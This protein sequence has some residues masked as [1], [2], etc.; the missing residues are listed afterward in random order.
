[1]LVLMGVLMARV[2]VEAVVVTAR[3]GRDREVDRH[4]ADEPQYQH[5]H[6]HHHHRHHLHRT[7]AVAV[8]VAVVLVE[9]D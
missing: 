9:I 1:M 6:Q 2:V 4:H 7:S 8:V 5:Q 3:Q